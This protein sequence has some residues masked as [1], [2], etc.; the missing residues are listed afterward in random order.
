MDVLAI[1]AVLARAPQL[2]AGHMQALLAAADGELTRSIEP[3]TL[4]RVEL[5]PPARAFLTLPDLAALDSDL[6]WIHSSGARLIASTDPDYPSQLLTVSNPPA[7]LFVL[8]NARQLAAPQLAMVGSRSPSYE[9]RERAHQFAACFAR[10]GLIVTSGLAL[11]ID[12]ASHEGAL[13]AGGAT[14]AVCGTGLDTVYPTQHAKLAGRIRANGALVSEFPP[15]TP[16]RRAN[17][18]QR[19]RLISGL[20]RG[21]LVVE[22]AQW[23]GSL[24]TARFAREQG[25]LVFALPGSLSNP[26]SRGCHQLLRE[27]ASLALHPGQVLSELGISLL[28]EELACGR[29]AHEQRGAMDKE[30]EMLLD[31]LGFEPVT[32]DVLVVRTGLPGE[33][34]ASLLLVLE[35]DGRIAPYPG[36]RFGRI[37]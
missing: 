28:N 22:A 4:A 30:Y 36:G 10:A 32:V 18:P 23:S 37:P 7:M 3:E 24:V 9:G 33:S 6:E 27:G 35:L 34:I 19:N 20:S 11:G 12:A 8:G 2:R 21:T 16:P 13:W 25:R 26:L 29:D 1:R 14:V 31:A 17:F 15:R 5:P